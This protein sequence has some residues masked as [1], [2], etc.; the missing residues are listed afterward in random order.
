MT[1]GMKKVAFV[2]APPILSV[3]LL[4]GIVAEQRT[5]LKREDVEPYHARAK[6]AVDAIPYIIGTWTGADQPVPQAAQ[7]LLKPPLV[8]E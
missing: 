2:L 1:S 3:T 7:K 4:A 8:D 6:A 5:H